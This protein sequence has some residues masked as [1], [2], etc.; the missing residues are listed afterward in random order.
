LFRSATNFDASMSWYASEDL[1]FQAA[2]FYKDIEDF[3]V[4]VNGATVALNELPLEIPVDSVTQFTIPSDIVLTNVNFATN[5][6]KA[7]VYGIELTYSQYFES[8]LFVQ[9]NA[10]FMNSEANVGD[11]L[12][13][14]EIQLP[15]QADNTVNLTL[16]WE[17]EDISARLIGNYRSKVLDRIGACSADAIT[18][19]AALGFAENCKEWADIYHDANFSL[20][21]KATYK[22]NEKVRVYF[23]AVN[24]TDEKSFYYYQGNEY[25]RGKSLYTSEAFGR[26]F[27]VGVNIDFM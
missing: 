21:F 22:V 23:D 2:V 7:K 5:G 27:Q 18:A 15:D 19:D 9:S 13:V 3:V 8:G 6:D 11:T 24:M 1:F 12:R 26:S 4:D 20:D 14:G 25:S 17:N 16:G 10:T